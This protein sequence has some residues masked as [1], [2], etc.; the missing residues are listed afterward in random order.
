[1]TSTQRLVEIH[2]EQCLQLGGFVVFKDL[3]G[4]FFTIHWPG[5]K[6]K[7]YRIGNTV[8]PGSLNGIGDHLHGSSGIVE[9]VIQR[10]SIIL[11]I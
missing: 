3:I 8:K 2:L 7:H 6:A 10:R 4:V 9:I 1:M 11:W 5:N